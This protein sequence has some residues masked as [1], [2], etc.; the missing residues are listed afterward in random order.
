[1]GLLDFRRQEVRSVRTYTGGLWR[2][3]NIAS[4]EIVLSSERRIATN[5]MRKRTRQHHPSAMAGLTCQDKGDQE[6]HWRPRI[7]LGVTTAMT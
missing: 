5:G 6:K 4:S 1:V 3:R 2:A 7:C